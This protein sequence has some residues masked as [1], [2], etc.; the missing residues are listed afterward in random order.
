MNE[1]NGLDLADPSRDLGHPFASIDSPPTRGGADRRVSASTAEL[2]PHLPATGD[3]RCLR[4]PVPRT[5]RP[6]GAAAVGQ[7]MVVVARNEEEAHRLADDLAAWLPTG[8]VRSS[9][10]APPCR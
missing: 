3:L 5:W 1:F 4:R 6:A 8:N 7:A 10:S 9:R 2:A